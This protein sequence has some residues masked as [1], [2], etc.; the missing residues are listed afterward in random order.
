M[1]NYTCKWMQTWDCISCTCLLKQQLNCHHHYG[2]RLE[3]CGY[4]DLY[5]STH[6]CSKHMNKATQD[7]LETKYNLLFGRKAKKSSYTEK[8]RLRLRKNF[9]A[10]LFGYWFYVYKMKYISSD[11]K[12]DAQISRRNTK[13]IYFP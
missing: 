3:F 12:T 2:H 1:H 10:H 13:T 9:N 11:R 6:T 8:E 7:L 4:R 5:T